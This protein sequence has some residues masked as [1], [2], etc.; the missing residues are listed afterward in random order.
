MNQL[1][2]HLHHQIEKTADLFWTRVRWEVVCSYLPTEREC[3]LLD[4]GAGTGLLGDVLRER[5]PA[6]RYTFVEP[7]ESL[8]RRL[9][10]IHGERANANDG[11]AYQAA[12][13][14]TA[15]DVLEHQ[16]DDRAF[17]GEIVSQMKPRAL[18]IV[19][20][21]ALPRL[22]SEW[23]EELGH[24]RRYDKERLHQ[25]LAPQPLEI[26]EVSYLFPEMIP[27]GWVRSR[28]QPS[29]RRK[30]AEGASEFPSLPPVVNEPLYQLG[31]LSARLRRRWPAGTSLLAVARRI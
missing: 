6:C 21:P 19:T 13:Y 7:I 18:L 9:E 17:A 29:G 15:L 28:R 5:L 12:D 31:R 10:R 3:L 23:D 26:L 4:V 8:A 27:F 25:C 11:W 24:F 1:E 14:V 30:G 20:V 22:W 2:H 16:E